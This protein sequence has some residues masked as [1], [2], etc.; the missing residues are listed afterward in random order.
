[1]K[2]HQFKQGQGGV[3]LGKEGEWRKYLE[4]LGG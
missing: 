3:G 4:Q 1:M 2:G